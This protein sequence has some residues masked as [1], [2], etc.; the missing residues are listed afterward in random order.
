[1]TQSEAN[2]KRMLLHACCGPCSLEPVRV[3]QERGLVPDIF[4]AN[5]NIAPASEYK[6]RLSTLKEW[7]QSEGITVTEGEYDP[8]KWQTLVGQPWAEGRLG[9]GG[10]QDTDTSVAVR[11]AEATVDAQYAAINADDQGVDAN[12]NTNADAQNDRRTERCRACYCM[13]FEEAAEWAV[14]HGYDAMGTTLSVS[15][16]QYT[17]IIRE[18]LERACAAHG[19]NAMFEDWRPYYPT[20]TRRSREAGMYRQNYCGCAFSAAEAEAE[21]VD[22]K[23]AREAARARKIREHAEERAAKE[24]DLAKRREERRAYDEKRTRQKA[25]LRALREERHKHV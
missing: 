18:E 1:M 12:T 9:D 6:H 5:S 22:R 10:A 14:Q 8:D 3:L 20:A 23:A 16:Y 11:D 15:P 7:A 13:R 4:Y 21:R 24:A 17:D 19:L 25:I 2:I